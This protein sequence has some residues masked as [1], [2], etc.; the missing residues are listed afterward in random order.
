[1]NPIN[2][3]I[4]RELSRMVQHIVETVTTKFKLAV[5]RVETTTQNITH[6]EQVCK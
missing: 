2:G 4:N 3:N 5:V 1:M 6:E